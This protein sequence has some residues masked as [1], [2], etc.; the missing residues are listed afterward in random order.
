MQ[1]DFT[2]LADI[3]YR[4]CPTAETRT[5]RAELV[6]KGFTIVEG[7]KIPFHESES[8]TQPPS[9][10]GKFPPLKSCD[11]SRDYRHFYRLVCNFHERH[12]PP[13][14]TEK[15]WEEVAADMSRIAE[16]DMKNDDF[17]MALLIDVMEELEREQ[18]RM[19]QE[20]ES[21][22]RSLPKATEGQK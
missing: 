14:L 13:Q 8:Q 3:A 19:A 11:G 18:K 20:A 10:K 15:Y 1:L 9:Q 12:N 5:A 2:K 4:D 21:G 6:A 16:T 7:E 17:G 22:P